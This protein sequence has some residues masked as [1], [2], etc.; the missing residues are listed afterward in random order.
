MPRNDNYPA[1]DVPPSLPRVKHNA[2]TKWLGRSILKLGG[3]RMEGEFPDVP[4][5][6]LIGAPH[7][8]NWDGVWGFSAKAAM[9]LDIRVL[10][11]DALF[12][13]P[14]LGSVL[15]RLG[16]LSVDRSN[17]AGIVEQ[18]AELIRSN[19]RFWYGLAPEG[20]RK[21]VDKWKQGFW[22]IARAA[23]V[24]VVPVYFDYARKVIGVGAKFELTDNVDADMERIVGWYRT[25]GRGRLHDI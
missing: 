25:V 12:R 20:T 13:V 8:S 4:R 10:G 18:A 9:G 2:L 5:A 17:P 24:P 23:D 6:V 19:D 7:S 16:V 22:R 11:K 14:V 1:L 15:R 21:K 3:W